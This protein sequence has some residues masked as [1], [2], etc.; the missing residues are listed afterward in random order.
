MQ[1]IPVDVSRMVFLAVEAPR[2]KLRDRRTGQV[3]TDRDGHPVTAIRCAC[4]PADE[5]SE[6]DAALEVIQTIAQVPAIK[7]GTPVQVNGLTA[8]P[9]AF[10]DERGE[11]KSGMTFWA[12]SI[13]PAGPAQQRPGGGS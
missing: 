9:Y 1:S 7:R 3:A 2:P 5:A 4:V 12:D 10:K 6:D 11:F 8:R 13:T